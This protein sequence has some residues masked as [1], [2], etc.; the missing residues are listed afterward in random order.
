MCQQFCHCLN[1]QHTDYISLRPDPGAIHT[2]A[3]T[4]NWVAPLQ[5]YALPSV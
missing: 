2:D 1:N 3:F 5:G 4:T